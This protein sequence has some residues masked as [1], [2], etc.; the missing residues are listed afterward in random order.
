MCPQTSETVDHLQM[1]ID[2]DIVHKEGESSLPS[3]ASWLFN[4]RY[5][6]W[7]EKY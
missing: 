7:K 3:L 5:E 1:Y 2:H 6:V 4:A